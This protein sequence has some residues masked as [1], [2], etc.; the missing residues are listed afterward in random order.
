M[1]YKP[2]KYANNNFSYSNLINNNNNNNKI[3]FIRNLSSNADK[4][5]NTDDNKN[6]VQSK[7]LF[8]YSLVIATISAILGIGLYKYSSNNKVAVVKDSQKQVSKKQYKSLS[9]NI[10]PTY[11]SNPTQ[12]V[13]STNVINFLQPIQDKYNKTNEFIN[14]YSKNTSKRFYRD[15]EF[16]KLLDK[17]YLLNDL[18]V[19]SIFKI[20]EYHHKTNGIN[21]YTNQIASNN[22]IEDYMTWSN[23][24]TT[25]T[26][27]NNDNGSLLMFGIFDGHAG[28][29]CS[30]TCVQ[31]IKPILDEALE[32]ISSNN[33]NT[34]AINND[35][36]DDNNNITKDIAIPNGPANTINESIETVKSIL[37]NNKEIDPISLAL[38]SSFYYIDYQ[39]T[40]K[41][42]NL[43]PTL[44]LDMFKDKDSN[45]N[46]GN[47]IDNLFGQSISGS[48][49]I[50]SVLDIINKKITV[51]NV[52][53]SRTILGIKPN[54][55]NW[56]S[57]PLS[58]DQTSKNPL[59]HQRLNK[60][61]PNEDMNEIFKRDRLFGAL[62]IS[63]AFGDCRYKWDLEKHKKYFDILYE[64]GHRYART[65]NEQV[66]KTPPYLTA[67]PDII[68]H[69]LNL[70][71]D[72]FII[73]ASDGLHDLIDNDLAVEIVGNW[74]DNY[75]KNKSNNKSNK[76]IIEFDA[77]PATYLM[78]SAY[79]YNK[80]S[81]EHTKHNI[82]R[83]LSIPPGF[84]RSIRDDLSVVVILLD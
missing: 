46:V 58:V 18:E 50:V 77:N 41:P 25:N 60:E 29:L 84:S 36:N 43:Y 11:P 4:R 19:N 37:P 62:A 34:K 80:E 54:D 55:N 64:R 65:I 51:A 53:D 42:P 70:E 3:L 26:L 40:N 27:N 24:T 6:K 21:I 71:T 38:M 16:W 61:H 12:K 75:Y 69:K 74:Y 73:M 56:K 7:P 63:R 32:I 14:S 2:N 59:E 48:C 15:E 35:S 1:V 9:D 13:A 57:I 47:I 76:E 79:V 8:K 20:N 33:T 81:N 28:Y 68:Q 10:Q 5:N 82:K 45:N 72:K 52:G 39:L 23:I 22:P 30:Q 17:D 31:T 83:L 66:F 49:A 44:S 78:K 67:F